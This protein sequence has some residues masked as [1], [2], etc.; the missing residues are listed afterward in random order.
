MKDHDPNKKYLIRELPGR[1]YLRHADSQV[2]ILPPFVP[3][4]DIPFLLSAHCS[5]IIADFKK[6]LR[7]SVSDFTF[8]ESFSLDDDTPLID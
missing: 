2:Q 7:Y 3:T 8:D 5:G 1:M 6:Y 4:N